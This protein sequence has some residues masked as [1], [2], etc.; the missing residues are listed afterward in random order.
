MS[1]ARHFKR[2]ALAFVMLFGFV[3]WVSAAPING[4]EF[5]FR[6][7]DGSMVRVVVWGD[8]F[9]QDVESPDGYALVRD[10]DGWICY[11][12]LSADGSE[13]VATGVR[14]T[15]TGKS[16]APG[17]S[18]G[19]RVNKDSVREKQRRGREAVGHDKLI[20]PR[21][22]AKPRTRQFSAALPGGTSPAPTLTEPV[23]VVGLTIPI[24]FPEEQSNITQEMI[25]EFCNR[26]GGVNGA[27][28]AG[29]VYDYFYDVS[30]GLLEYT[31][32]VT[33]FVTVDNSKEYYERGND[34]IR[35]IL[36]WEFITSA[37]N[38]LKAM[39][40]DLEGV[41]VD[42]DSGR[43]NVVALNLF[44]A[45]NTGSGWS[46][47]L[48]PHAG[49]YAPYRPF[50]TSADKQAAVTIN[51]I[52]F[53][54]Y[55]MTGLGTGSNPP[56]IGTFVHESG[57]LVMGWPDLYSY[58]NDGTS[59]IIGSWCVMSSQNNNN[60]QYPNAYLRY[61]A[62]WIDAVDIT[63][64]EVGTPFY[65]VANGP[66]AYVYRRNAIEAYFIEARRRVGRNANTPGSGLAVWHIHEYGYNRSDDAGF[67]LV[68]LMQADGRNDLE[69]GVNKGDA[70]DLFR[71]SVQTNFNKATI[72]AAFYHDETASDISITEISD[73]GEVMTFR[74]GDPVHIDGGK[75]PFSGGS[76][77]EDDPY[78]I[79]NA[80]ELAKMAELASRYWGY[81]RCAYKLINDIDLSEYGENYNGGKGW[82]PIG[83]NGF[84]SAG[85]WFSFNGIFDGNN[86]IITGL[87]I[88]N[89]TLNN[90]GLFGRIIDGGTI[91]NLGIVGVAISVGNVVGGVVGSN[92][93]SVTNCYSMGTVN[94]GNWV[95]GV[96]GSNYGS[97]TNCYSTGTVSGGNQIGGV[98][99]WSTGIVN[100]CYS[101]NT[102]NG[103]DYVGGVVGV[104]S[105]SSVTNCYS[106]GTVNGG[107]Y[108]G[109]V[110]GYS[111]NGSV[112]TN[113]YSTGAVSGSSSIGG[114][115]GYVE[116]GGSVKNCVALNPSVKIKTE[117]YGVGRVTGVNNNIV[118]NNAA[119][120]GMT[121]NNGNTDWFYDGASNKDG[122]GLSVGA[123][124]ADGT[125][126]GRFTAEN[127]W[128]TENGKL[129]GLFGKAV[130]MPSHLIGV[131]IASADRVIPPTGN[132][133]TVVVAPVAPQTGEFTA[134]PNPA[135]K[136][137]GGI[138]FFWNG[139]RI[140]SGALAVYGASGN[141][142]RKLAIKDNAVTG[143]VR[144]RAVGSWDLKD[145]KGRQVFDGTYLVKGKVVTFGGKGE[146]VSVV[147]GVR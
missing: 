124:N 78:L 107:D 34:S 77:A 93:G 86:K 146:R 33:P 143:N 95:G 80:A 72:P 74:I 82:V 120:S 64:A 51:G 76:G 62:G 61:L 58:R 31:N 66:A 53:S 115:A 2:L 36:R 40:F 147:V 27:N 29:S 5:Q 132:A 46:Q 108:V 116:G 106:T 14:Y 125:L 16:R 126:G 69:N 145:S 1:T 21:S 100:N 60:P 99:G 68:A 41:T 48:W 7:P 94:G 28:P 127:G 37:L 119:F 71:A 103:G 84:V 55:Q 57:H 98:V 24:N 137:S 19:L 52:R 22:F 26:P 87:Y 38:K 10:G 123:I 88:N 50:D 89:T 140:K 8:E 134:G 56:P 83:S 109:G 30:D 130:E 6:Q 4:G 79:S 97:V 65:H 44:Y 43:Y 128:T 75:G 101:T 20:G 121:N 118:E 105:N 102:M 25:D 70:T 96:V 39:N 42:T 136:S 85:T 131:S 81:S 112:V 35:T 122:A 49:T 12:E 67:P 142:V 45:G 47:G 113:C 129:P 139:K 138:A 73:S 23:R 3:V 104:S 11:A 59:S 114:V 15:G 133:E 54:R 63:S 92:N 117:Y 9:Y 91:K 110:V 18:K 32:I 135:G 144:K 13:Y 141:V 17:V 90:A 111:Y